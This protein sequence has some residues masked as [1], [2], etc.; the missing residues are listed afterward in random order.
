MH[1]DVGDDGKP[2]LLAQLPEASEVLSI[3]PNDPGVEALRVDVVVKYVVHDAS[4]TVA[5]VAEEESTALS[6][7]TAAS[8]AKAL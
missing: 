4:P 2:A 7:S 3:E 5:A 6:A 1:M 8:F